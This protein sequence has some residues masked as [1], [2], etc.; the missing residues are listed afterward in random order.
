MPSPL[1]AIRAGIDY[2][3]RHPTELIYVAKSAAG[4]KVVLPLDALRW[5][6]DNSK[7]GKRAPKEVVIGGKPPA[8][9]VAAT[10]DLMGTPVRAGAA[11]KFEE[12]RLGPDELRIV[13]KLSDV[14]LQALGDANTPVGALL[15]SGALDLSKP[16]NLAN[17]LP[18]RPPALVEAR[19]DLIALDLM[20]VPKI[21]EN[22]RL[23]RILG[24]V[25]PV[26][27][28]REV[29][30]A[31]DHLILSWRPRPGGVLS[32]VAALRS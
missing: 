26:F 27:E 2:L 6:S 15:K 9:T 13:L 3:R 7:G 18:K 30:V 17:F 19:D 21:A 14:T 5:L 12:L 29:R 4:L 10:L 25:T 31:D 22:A 23:R 11:I 8:I 16:G 1:K 28:I 32:A 20:K 24:V